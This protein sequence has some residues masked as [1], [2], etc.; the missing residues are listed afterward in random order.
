MT[1]DC[2]TS[3]NLVELYGSSQTDADRLGSAGTV[4]SGLQSDG[5]RDLQPGAMDESF[6]MQIIVVV[7]I[8]KE[9]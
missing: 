4:G 6:I 8:T 2:V 9:E 7:S 1:H 5:I 3:A